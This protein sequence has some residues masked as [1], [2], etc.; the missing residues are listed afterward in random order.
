LLVG[1]S[2]M[3]DRVLIDS[4]G[5]YLTQPRAGAGAKQ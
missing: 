1:R 2:F 4:G 3:L 5:E